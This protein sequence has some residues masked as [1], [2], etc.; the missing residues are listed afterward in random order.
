MLLLFNRE[1][2]NVGADTKNKSTKKIVGYDSTFLLMAIVV[3]NCILSIYKLDQT[4]LKTFSMCDFGFLVPIMTLGFTSIDIWI[5]YRGIKKN[6]LVFWAKLLSFVSFCIVVV[7]FGVA[8]L[9]W[10]QII[11]IAPNQHFFLD[12]NIVTYI[13]GKPVVGCSQAIVLVFYTLAAF[14]QGGAN[15]FKVFYNKQNIK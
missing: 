13:V 7:I 15:T 8:F 12:G 14:F 1:A 3:L 11:K 5:S 10:A 6:S 9:V 4:D 2:Y